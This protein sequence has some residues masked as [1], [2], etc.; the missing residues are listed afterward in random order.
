MT[1]GE[2]IKGF[3][4][5]P[6]MAAMKFSREMNSLLS[7]FQDDRANALA[8]SIH[9]QATAGA[10]LAMVKQDLRKWQK[11][12]KDLERKLM[13]CGCDLPRAPDETD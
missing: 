6:D 9:G 11:Y 8:Q 4:F 7:A 5:G 13:Q 2:R 3:F 1:I 10:E 12:A